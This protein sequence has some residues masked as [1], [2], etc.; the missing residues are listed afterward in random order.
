MTDMYSLQQKLTE[1]VVDGYMRREIPE[2]CDGSCAEGKFEYVNALYRVKY[3]VSYPDGTWVDPAV[4]GDDPV[5][6]PFDATQV[7]TSLK[8]AVEEWL[9]PFLDIP[10]PSGFDDTI[11]MLQDAANSLRAGGRVEL[12]GDGSGTKIQVG[13]EPLDAYIKVIEAELSDLNGRAMKRLR[14][15]YGN[16]IRNTVS[17]QHALVVVAGTLVA[18]ER[19]A[20]KRVDQDITAIVTDATGAF[21]DFA[22]SAEVSAGDALTVLGTVSE[23]A[24][25]F[26]IP[27]G[28][29]G[30]AIGKAE[31]V[32]EL[33]SPFMPKAPAAKDYSIK[34][35]TFDEL[36]ESFTTAIQDLNTGLTNTEDAFSQCAV[37]AGEA[38]ATN[39]TSFNL[40]RPDEF[41]NANAQ[42]DDIYETEAGGRDDEI[43]VNDALKYCAGR[44]ELI[45]DHQRKIA[46]MLG[47]GVFEAMPGGP[48]HAQ[49]GG[50]PSWERDGWSGA[51][52]GLSFYGHYP[53][54]QT[55]LTSI[56]DLLIGEAKEAHRV[57]EQ[58]LLALS[59]FTA[60][61]GQ[62]EADLNRH[63][64]R[65]Q[66]E[67]EANL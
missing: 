7:Y 54:Y 55:L 35:G 44:F 30:T 52:L 34:G 4:M 3:D 1:A 2:I 9:K 5:D 64:V 16:R 6:A 39:R 20:W 66:K 25:L 42:N 53:A 38:S 18:G 50:K 21:S 56:V 40:S 67:V 32:R 12:S 27:L 19:E 62:V 17:G 8:T 37:N 13:D 10:K 28:A 23:A 58:C 14:D 57:A 22:K 43:K 46:G 59:D 51:P 41:L 24:A 65:V 29:A 15:Y 33:V 49:P 26:G 45:G 63:A 48:S 61:D 11:G 36:W 60:T 31:T 47:R